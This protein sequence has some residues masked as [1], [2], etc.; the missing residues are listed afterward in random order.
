[1]ILYLRKNIDFKVYS[2]NI[3][4]INKFL[5]EN[6]MNYRLFKITFP[7]YLLLLLIL[8]ISNSFAQ[9]NSIVKHPEW[10]YNS[11]IYEVNLRQYTEEGTFK[12]F[13][14]H[15]PRLKEMGVGIL[16]FM[17]IHPIGE[18]TG[19]VL[20]A[21]TMLLKIIKTLIRNM[22]LL[23]ILKTLLIKFTKWICM[24]LLIGWLTILRGIIFG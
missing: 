3:Y 7:G 21:A 19:K 20:L 5:N 15:L 16:W 2:F 6:I 4:Y 1:M 24:L 9:N 8:I 10:S 22:E 14:E 13:E 18:K 23:K 11:V 12:S 17:P